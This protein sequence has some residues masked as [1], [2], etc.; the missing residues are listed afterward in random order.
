MS[1]VGG[2]WSEVGERVE[3]LALKLK[4]HFEQAGRPEEATDPLRKV[5]DSLTDAFEA[6]GNAVRDDAVKA[7]VRETGRLFLDALSVS[8]AKAADSLRDKAADASRL[9][10]RQPTPS[11]PSRSSRLR[12][13]SRPSPAGDRTGRR[14]FGVA[15][16][17][18][19]TRESPVRWGVRPP[20]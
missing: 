6:A 2:R 8:L 3:A 11:R 5:R 20:G 12:C 17:V 16:R 18:R 9:T 4:L 10:P 15:A 7:D 13:R 1:D 14:A 19:R